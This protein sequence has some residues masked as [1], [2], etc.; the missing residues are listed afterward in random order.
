MSAKCSQR[1]SVKHS[2]KHSSTSSLKMNRTPQA[3]KNLYES[4]G[5]PKTANKQTIKKAYRSRVKKHHTDKGGNIEDFL[6]VQLA[7]DVLSDDEKR[8]RY[9]ETG[10]SEGGPE[11]KAEQIFMQLVLKAI[12]AAEDNPLA[13]AIDMLKHQIMEAQSNIAMI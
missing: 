5:V 7:Y 12:D 11:S 3:T 6:R 4:L 1:L 10:L 2:Q 9:D 13:S 8:K